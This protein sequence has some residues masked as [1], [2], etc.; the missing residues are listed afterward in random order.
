MKFIATKL[1]A[2]LSM[3]CQ[4]RCSDYAKRMSTPWDTIELIFVPAYNQACAENTQKAKR[5]V[6]LPGPP[7]CPGGR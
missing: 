7:G 5:S 6:S 3:K 4:L 2:K 1:A